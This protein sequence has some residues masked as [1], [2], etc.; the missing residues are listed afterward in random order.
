MP[1]EFKKPKRIVI[2]EMDYISHIL[3]N[4][5]IKDLQENE[6][7]C[8]ECHGTGL[9]IYDARYGLSND[10]DKTIELFP[11]KQQTISICRNCYN[12]VLELCPYCGKTLTRGKSQCDCDGL[13]TKQKQIELEKE[14]ELFNKST[15]L[16]CNEIK[17]HSIK[18]FYSDAFPYN[19]G[20]FC[21]WIDFFDC[22][23]DNHSKD[24]P[25]PKYVWG[26]TETNLDL[27]AYDIVENATEDLWEGAYDSISQSDIDELDK[28]L[29]KWAK[30]QTGTKSYMVNYKYSILIPWELSE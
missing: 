1:E 7:I 4:G 24:D 19:E 29:K 12:G 9:A 15:K 18:M 6:I 27:C 22:C 23:N 10:T 8:P 20:Y 17:T 30:K 25:K 5:L 2:N 28:Y 11:Y 21:E 16:N 14:Q 13:K 3:E 26:T